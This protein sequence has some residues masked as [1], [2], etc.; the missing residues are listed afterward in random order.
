VEVVL[1]TAE[2]AGAESGT[3]AP[4]EVE[5]RRHLAAIMFTSGSTGELKGVMVT[6]QNIL[7]NTEDILSYMRLD[8]DDR[9]M[10]VLPFFYCYGT[11]LLHT[12]LMAGG[13]L[14]INNRFLF[15]EKVLDEMAEKGCTGLAGVPATY[16]ILLRKTR[17][18]QRRFP[19][20]RWL[21]QAGGRLPN[22]LVRELRQALPG[23]Q[24]FVMYGQTEATARLSYL[25]PDKLDD[26]PGSIGC[27][28]PHVRLEVLRP[29]GTP[30]RPGSDEVGQI[31]AAGESITTGYWGDADETARYF[32]DGKLYTGDMARVDADGFVFIVERARDFIKA[33]GYRVSPKE[34]EEVLAEMPEILEAAVIGAADELWGEAI[35]AF[36]VTVRPGQLTADQV[37]SH[38]LARLPNYKVPQHVEFLPRLPKLGNG[39]VDRKTLKEL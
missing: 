33:M 2:L 34:V 17:L 28:L 20:L 8:P 9:A 10:V 11:S 6:H 22:P 18:A 30:V 5:L 4:V 23:V 16:Q 36:V 26:K 12:H 31:A 39:K 15:P 14:V 27:G 21:Q 35:R 29:D 38:C 25:P 7:V 24:I 19:S 13:S 32:R 37:R 3:A 1:E